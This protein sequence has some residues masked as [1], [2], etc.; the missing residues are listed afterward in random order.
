MLV[1][2]LLDFLDAVCTFEDAVDEGFVY[3]HVLGGGLGLLR[4]R[5][6]EVLVFVD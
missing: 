5:R 4:A 1:L 6:L 2:L 3:L